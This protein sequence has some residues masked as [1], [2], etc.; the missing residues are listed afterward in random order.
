MDGCIDWTAPPSHI[1]SS[2]PVWMVTCSVV[3]PHGNAKLTAPGLALHPTAPVSEK[4]VRYGRGFVKLKIEMK[5]C[6]FPIN[7]NGL[8]SVSL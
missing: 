2:I 6:F 3:P 7:Q 1:R 5:A 4:Q 8:S